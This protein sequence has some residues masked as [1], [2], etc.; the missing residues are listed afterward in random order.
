MAT[1]LPTDLLRSFVAIVDA[2][3]MLRATER[4]FLSQSALS[5]QMR[6]LEKI[7]RVPLFHRHGR[8]LTLTPAGQH[9]LHQARQILDLNDRIL[10]SLAGE[11]LSGAVHIGLVQDFAETLLSGALGVFAAAH[12]EAQL[13]VKVA[14]SQNLMDALRDHHLDVVLSILPDGEEAALRRVPAVW[15]GEP[16]LAGQEILPLALL[17]MPC[18]FRATALRALEAAGRRFRIVVETPS[19]SGLRAAVQTGLGIT[20]RTNLFAEAASAPVIPKDLLPP[21]PHVSYALHTVENPTAPAKRIADL[22][23]TALNEEN[24]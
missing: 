16:E 15:I 19:L 4:I 20:C 17:E 14:D 6:R 22:I 13:Q 21:L 7:V 9:L 8:K 23:R 18:L 5:L 24:I 10:T 11:P 12:P 2:G 1:N 3:S